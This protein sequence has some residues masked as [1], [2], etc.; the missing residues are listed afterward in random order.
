MSAA[1]VQRAGAITRRAAP[2]L[3]DTT[4]RRRLPQTSLRGNQ[5]FHK[6]P[7][8]FVLARS[9]IDHARCVTKLPAG[10]AFRGDDG[11]G[12]G[13]S[14]PQVHRDREPLPPTRKPSFPLALMAAAVLAPLSSVPQKQRH[15]AGEPTSSTAVATHDTS[16]TDSSWA[17]DEPSMDEEES[18]HA[19]KMAVLELLAHPRE[20]GAAMMD[21]AAAAAEHHHHHHSSSSS[22]NSNAS[23]DGPRNPPFIN[24]QYI[25]AV[26]TAAVQPS[27]GAC[28]AC[29]CTHYM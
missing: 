19:A 3:R 5:S 11:G 20:T 2:R 4:E 1:V 25:D 18:E 28:A 29:T 26:V 15:P 21:A 9:W 12:G 22:S 17:S 10:H 8:C 16:A 14:A 27:I 13:A 7:L 23:S 6:D 24:P